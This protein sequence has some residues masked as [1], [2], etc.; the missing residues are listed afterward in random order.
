MVPPPTSY[1]VAPGSVG[2]RRSRSLAPEP[3]LTATA[4]LP[5]VRDALVGEDAGQVVEGTRADVDDDAAR[6]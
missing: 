1:Q 4:S 2:A 5:E 6:G 3:P